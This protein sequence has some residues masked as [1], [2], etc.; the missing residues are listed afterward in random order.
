MPKSDTWQDGNALDTM[1]EMDSTGSC[2]SV[3]SFNLCFSDDDSL[4]YLSAEEKACLMFLEETIQSLDTEDD[5]GLSNDESDKLPVRGNV[6]TKAAHL[7]ASI[8]LKKL[9][10]QDIPKLHS[11][12]PLSSGSPIQSE[13]LNY[14]VPTP[15]VLANRNSQ[16][17]DRTGLAASCKKEL[18]N[19]STDSTQ[20]FQ[21]VPRVPSEINVVVLPPPHKI[22]G[23]KGSVIE[24]PND[25]CSEIL[26]HRG[27]LPYENLVQLCK[28]ASMQKTNADE[29][30]TGED[31]S[32]NLHRSNEGRT[33]RSKTL[34]QNSE[35]MES[36]SSKPTPPPVAPK[37]KMKSP[38]K[39][40]MD[41]EGVTFPS[42]MSSSGVLPVDKLM[43]PEK[44]R[45]EAL[46]KLGLLKEEASNSRQHMTTGQN[47][48][49]QQLK[50]SQFPAKS[51]QNQTIGEP[52]PP[53]V[54]ARPGKLIN[55]PVQSC[56]PLRQRSMS[57]LCTA[58]SRPQHASMTSAG[59]AATLEC[60]GM[61]G[62]ICTSNHGSSS[63]SMTDLNTVSQNH[64][65]CSSTHG[66]K[67]NLRDTQ[68]DANESTLGKAQE[69]QQVSSSHSK[70]T[71]VQ[72]LNVL[73]H[74]IGKDRREALRKL[75]LLKN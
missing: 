72:G 56:N 68:M 28:S 16:I 67:N 40:P 54:A 32:T 59:K 74:S 58:P 66:I 10:A 6:A 9:S 25:Q 4:E 61:E 34:N 2:D 27:P 12:G 36:R 8:G 29:P 75:G 71:H 5:S 51:V 1:G 14:M 20:L 63:S 57:D 11:E 21:E 65:S 53:C 24:K 33:S 42:N 31:F 35:A 69:S 17:P 62:Q 18:R 22:K 23:N 48:T 50:H 47:P 43:N 73:V 55:Q 64:Q 44:V 45:M 41:Q 38:Q 15:F 37:P 13:I 60:N 52:L 3:V 30:K 46:Y 70:S 39:A 26:P 49:S 7:S 19:V